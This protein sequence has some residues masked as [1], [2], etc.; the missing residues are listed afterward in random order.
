MSNLVS[1]GTV[2]H[3]GQ[4]LGGQFGARLLDL[5]GETT[6][7]QRRLW[8]MGTVLA[9]RELHEAGPW[10][11]AQVLSPAALQWLCRD[12]ER[13]AGDDAGLGAPELRRQLREVLRA[14]LSQ[15]SRQRR[16]LHE[17]IA[18]IDES[19]VPRWTAAAHSPEGVSFERLARAVAAHLLDRG[20]SMGFLHRTLRRR[21][22]TGATVGDFLAEAGQLASASPRQFE[23]LVPFLIVPQQQLAEGLPQWRPRPQVRDWL[24]AHAPGDAVRQNGAFLYSIEAMDPYT[25]GRQVGEILDRLLARSSFLRRRRSGLTPLGRLWVAGLDESLPLEPPARG[26]DILSLR[27]DGTLYRII[28]EDLLDNVLE[29]AAPLNRGARGPAVAGGWAALESLLYHAGDPADRKDGRAI[30]A[31]RMAALVTC[32]WPRAELTALSHA[33]KPATPDLLARQLANAASNRER[34]IAVASVLRSGRTLATKHPADA[35]AAARM[36]ALVASPQRSLLGVRTTVEGT[37]RRLYRQRNI[38]LHGGSTQA[39]ALD[40]TLRTC[41]PLVGAGL[42]RIAHA[43]LAD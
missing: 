8:S 17:L 11:D 23:V 43:Y 31:A 32:S 41:A 37:L 30:A 42:D 25:A 13:L 33:H 10:V 22:A 35:A 5:T 14:D 29:L 1:L 24:A 3:A 40:A 12:L 26:V 2:P 9:L 21:I 19:Y 27:K 4:P 6:P 15:H 38:V 16:R 34:A 39:V 20:Y 28:D 7:W 18:L 36:S